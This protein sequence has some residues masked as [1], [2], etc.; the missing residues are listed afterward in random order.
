[1]TDSSY[2]RYSYRYRAAEIRLIFDCIKQGQSLC[3]VGIAGTGKSNIP[4]FLNTFAKNVESSS[5]SEEDIHAI[6]PV[7]DGNTWDQT[8]I[9]LWQ[10]MLAALGDVTSHL[11]P[12]EPDGKIIHFSEEQKAF[13]ELKSHVDWFCQKLEQQLIFVLDD[14]DQVLAIGPLAMLEQ[15]NALRSSGNRGKLSYLLFTKKL[16]HVLG[17]N[18]P[19]KGTAKFY[20][21]FSSHI[22]ALG[23]YNHED[24]RQMLVHL[25]ELAGKSLTTRELTLIESLAGGH[26]RLLKVIFELW[27]NEVPETADFVTAFAGKSDVRDECQRILRSL[28]QAE[29]ET[30]LRVAREQQTAADQDI[31]DHLMRR[32]LL[33][34]SGKLEWFSPLFAAFLRTYSA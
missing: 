10:I 8:P 13:S 31:I 27:R 6:F 22:Y 15:L 2:N 30:A 18:H 34:N 11:P 14:F 17:R 9:G 1:M 5:S 21:L 16:P 28:H 32:G 19:L 12:P 20:D 3:F 24:A 23:L 4:N 7:V 25:N 29:Q 33:V 26:A